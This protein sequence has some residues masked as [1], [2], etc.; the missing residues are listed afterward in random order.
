MYVNNTT[1]QKFEKKE[2][3][4]KTDK[5]RVLSEFKLKEEN[6]RQMDV[7]FN[8]MVRKQNNEMDVRLD[9]I[10]MSLEKKLDNSN[11]EIRRA[12][13]QMNLENKRMI[14]AVKDELSEVKWDIDKVNK[15]VDAVS[16]E[17]K[18]SF[19]KLEKKT[20]NEKEKSLIYEV[21]LVDC[22]DKMKNLH[23][24]LLLPNE[25]KEIGDSI[26]FIQNDI[27]VGIYAA[28]IS[29]AQTKIVDAT[30]YYAELEVMNQRF[31][32]LC[33]EI[34]VLELKIDEY[35]N[36]P[37]DESPP[38]DGSVPEGKNVK[39]WSDGQYTI[40]NEEY[41]TIKSD[42]KK[43][44]KQMD[45]DGMQMIKDSLDKLLD[46]FQ[47]CK[48]YATRRVCDFDAVVNLAI[49]ATIVMK[50]Q[51]WTETKGEFI[52]GDYRNNYIGEFN[53]GAGQEAVL[54]VLSCRDLS[55]TRLPN[56][57]T[58]YES[59]DVEYV[60]NLY[61]YH[62]EEMQ[63]V[64]KEIIDNMSGEGVTVYN[65]KEKKLVYEEYKKLRETRL[66]HIKN[67]LGMIE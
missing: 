4:L 59:G 14:D 30:K 66:N 16:D 46:G 27:E 20:K 7:S 8:E 2:K 29:L 53:N 63:I 64:W 42:E 48:D 44:L 54:E 62:E 10:R 18:R 37:F 3:Q 25:V 52:D 5:G 32:N 28:G 17:I 56:G 49:K 13:G 23:G 9:K 34:K 21:S 41:L 35:V 19:E 36:I 51:G 22:Y 45:I 50:L 39:Y 58:I 15:K 40:L 11:I 24:E 33:N 43:Y 57:K 12:I 65:T 38:S 47:K 26:I 1:Y 67:V 6:A 55:K 31:D 60:L 61:G